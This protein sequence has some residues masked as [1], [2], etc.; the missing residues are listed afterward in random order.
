MQKVP[1]GKGREEQDLFRRI[2]SQAHMR[3]R[4]LCKS[5]ICNT[6]PGCGETLSK[7]AA[8]RLVR[9]ISEPAKRAPLRPLPEA[10]FARANRPRDSGAWR[11]ACGGYVLARSFP[12]RSKAPPWRPSSCLVYIT[13]I[14]GPINETGL[15][16]PLLTVGPTA[17][18]FK[19]HKEVLIHLPNRGR[20]LLAP[21]RG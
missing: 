20:Y 11:R 18:P 4:Y 9:D 2:R 12:A 1:R 13:C 17:S 5:A 7:A 21:N 3:T 8:G 6:A 16:P 10:P 15:R 14:I 19:Q